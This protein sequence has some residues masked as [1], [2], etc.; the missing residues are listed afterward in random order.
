MLN[1]LTTG[2]SL[3]QLEETLPARLLVHIPYAFVTNTA[4]TVLL[5]VAEEWLLLT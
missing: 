1:H 2:R 5:T 4:G 3:I